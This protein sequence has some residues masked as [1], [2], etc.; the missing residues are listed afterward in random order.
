[1]KWLE[2]DR[3]R[4]R[5]LEPE[6]LQYLYRWEND[7]RLWEYGNTLSPF[8]RYVLHRYIESAT[9]DIYASKQL[10]LMVVD[11]ASDAVMGTVDM[12]DFEPFHGRAGVGI[13]LDEAYQGKGYAREGLSLVKDYAFNFLHLNQLYAHIPWNNLPSLRLFRRIGFVESACLKQW[14]RTAEG[15]QDVFVYQLFNDSSCECRC[16]EQV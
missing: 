15:W 13:L 14:S 5:S 16:S 9:S 7:T 3:I 1:M 6:D 2:S 11:K 10:R 4:L 8:S 12:Y